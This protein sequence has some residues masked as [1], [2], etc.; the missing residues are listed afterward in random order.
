MVQPELI[1]FICVNLCLS[2]LICGFK[3]RIS[4]AADDNGLTQIHADKE[5]R[6]K[7]NSDAN[8]FDIICQL[9]VDS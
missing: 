6:D 8:R 4:L 9:S 2:A 1:S 3:K 5:K 7:N